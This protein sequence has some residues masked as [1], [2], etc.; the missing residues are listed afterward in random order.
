VT[1]HA[2]MRAA[3]YDTVGEGRGVIRIAELPR[4]EP[5]PGE[6]RVR[7]S[8]SGV[9]PTDWKT[10][11]A[12]PGAIRAFP[13]VVPNQDGAG[14]IDAIG[15]HVDP[16]RLG[17]RVWLYNAQWR[18]AHGTAAQWVALPAEQAVPLPP[19]VGFDLGAGLGIPALT[20]HRCLFADGPVRGA[21]ILVHGGG[22]AVG[23]AAIELARWGGARVV[24]TVSSP[25]KAALAQAAGADLVLNYRTDDVV[26]EVRDFAPDGV[27][28]V[29]EVAL[30]E[31]VQVDAQAIS[32][33]A[34]ITSY[35]R[36]ETAFSLPRS[37]LELNA[38]LSFVLVYTIPTEAKQQ[39]VADITTALAAGA[40]T[41]LPTIRFQLDEAAAAHEAVEH[42]A[43]GKVLIDVD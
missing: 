9:N 32:P 7:V 13:Q 38:R 24:T 16:L 37:L 26:A 11:I 39:A 33:G 27:D 35:T 3:V 34:T 17:E 20:A 1:V 43:V 42:A 10:R 23:H 6:V 19:G 18:R 8:V 14:E 22:G 2:T 25:E 29:I 15:D 36:T 28:R 21:A 5:G 41:S 31:N 40:L 4:P 30:P 12:P